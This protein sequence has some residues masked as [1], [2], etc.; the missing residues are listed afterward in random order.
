MIVNKEIEKTY[1][2]HDGIE[3][4]WAVYSE[5]KHKIP[6]FM[7]DFIDQSVNKGENLDNEIKN[8]TLLT[9]FNCFDEIHS[10]LNLSSEN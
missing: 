1:I 9:P 10:H 7:R 4:K 3:N 5:F 8:K 2:T 6:Q